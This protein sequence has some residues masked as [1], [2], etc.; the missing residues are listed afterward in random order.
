MSSR[1]PP[2]PRFVTQPW[3]LVAPGEQPLGRGQLLLHDGSEKTTGRPR[4]CMLTPRTVVERGSQCEGRGLDPQRCHTRASHG[5]RGQVVAGTDV[6]DSVRRPPRAA[7]VC[8]DKEHHRPILPAL[9]P[10]HRQGSATR[11]SCCATGV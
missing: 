6:V 7:I 1:N 3:Q 10:M 8:S 11:Q 4:R 5:E 9:Q 2:P